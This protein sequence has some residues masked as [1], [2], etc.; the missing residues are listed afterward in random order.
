MNIE[1]LVCQSGAHTNKHRIVRLQRIQGPVLVLEHLL[2]RAARPARH[3][4][5]RIAD[6]V[7]KH[8]LLLS[9]QRP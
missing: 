2:V 4:P 5:I 9:E 1:Y 7:A 6:S 3:A 8:P